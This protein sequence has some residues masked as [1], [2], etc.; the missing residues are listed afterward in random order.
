MVLINTPSLILQTMFKLLVILFKIKFLSYFT[1]FSNVS[2]FDFDQINV[3]WAMIKSMREWVNLHKYHFV[4]TG[5]KTLKET[6]SIFNK[7]L[8]FL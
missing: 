5:K 6:K 1:P 3:S 7:L 4:C 2:V 8:S